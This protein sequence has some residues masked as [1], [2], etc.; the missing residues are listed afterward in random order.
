M[1]GLYIQF[2]LLCLNWQ[3]IIIYTDALQ[4][5]EDNIYS[6]LNVGLKTTETETKRKRKENLITIFVVFQVVVWSRPSE[7]RKVLLVV[8]LQ[9]VAPLSSKTQKGRWQAARQGHQSLG[10]ADTQDGQKPFERRSSTESPQ[11]VIHAYLAVLL[12]F[13]ITAAESRPFL[14]WR[15]V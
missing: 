5:K 9:E 2:I 11:R 12:Q 7:L 4:K 14:P 15:S 13:L 6:D 8:E 10:A 3:L 1:W